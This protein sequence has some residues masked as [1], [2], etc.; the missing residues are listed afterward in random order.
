M[1]GTIPMTKGDGDIVACRHRH[2]L[3]PFP[4]TSTETDALALCLDL[5]TIKVQ[6]LKQESVGFVLGMLYCIL[7]KNRKL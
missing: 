1:F 7:E 2:N 3:G 6:D 5:S 4:K